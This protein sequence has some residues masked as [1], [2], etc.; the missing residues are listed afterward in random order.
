MK[1]VLSFLEDVFCGESEGFKVPDTLK[2]AAVDGWM[3]LATTAPPRYM[4]HTLRS[5]LLPKFLLL[6]DSPC[7]EL[8]LAAGEAIAVLNEHW[9]SKEGFAY[10]DEE[11]AVLDAILDK[12]QELAREGS[13]RMSR[14]DKKAQRK[15]F[16]EIEASVLENEPPEEVLSYRNRSFRLTSWAKIVQ[17]EALRDALQGG[18]LH[19]LAANPVVHDI[20]EIEQGLFEEAQERNVVHKTSELSKFRTCARTRSRRSRENAKQHFFEGDEG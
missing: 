6:L 7:P 5:R 14:R 16:R 20:L 2:A 3:L 8:K 9:V 17:V 11:A 15:S 10:P 1:Q 19:H 12:L 13:K 4:T 18:F